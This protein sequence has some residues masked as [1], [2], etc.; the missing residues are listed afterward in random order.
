MA[1]T[2]YLRST[3]GLDSD[4][5]STWA[6]AKATLAGASGIGSVD[7]AGDTIYISQ[8]HAETASAVTTYT[9]AGTTSNPQ[10]LICGNDAAEP[11]TALAT[12][13]VITNTATSGVNNLNGSFYAYGIKWQFAATLQPGGTGVNVDGFQFYENCTFDCTG[14]GSSG[15]IVTTQDNDAFKITFLN[16]SYKFANAANYIQIS[17]SLEIKGG[18]I[19]SG[20]A[21]P[22]PLFKLPTD[23]T[24]LRATIDG[25]DL[26]NFASTLVLFSGSGVPAAKVVIR[27]CKLPA[28]WT[29][30]LTSA[31]PHIGQR[32]EMRNCSS[33]GTNY[34]FWVEDYAG[35]I[36][37]ETT[38]IK[39]GG[40][41]NGT[42][43]FSMKMTSTANT[44]Y[45]GNVLQSLDME[46]WVDSTGSALTAT[47]DIVHDSLTNL[48]D[49]EVWIEIEYMGSSSSPVATFLTDAKTDIM[50]LAA[51]QTTSSATWTT[52]GL[53]NP[54]KQKLNVTFTPQLKGP[55]LARVMLAKASKTIYVDSTVQV[56]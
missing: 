38:I 5:A 49:G 11:P 42:T 18:S 12:G 35:T 17:Q 30:T 2:R 26:S 4:D 32:F 16:C 6:L 14:A 24:M 3:D 48:T 56:A 46:G 45:P 34:A 20:S 31:A 21:T 19:V 10:K 25:M 7:T 47:I 55:I 36:K 22:N 40:S 33:T 9:G 43:G 50:A 44:T 15:N 13:A 51:D 39:T 53:T 27:N 8:V 54:N 52:T 23:R 28:S 1:S 29:G 41:T 37:H